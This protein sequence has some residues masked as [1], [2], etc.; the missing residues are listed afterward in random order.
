MGGVNSHMYGYFKMLMLKGFMA[1][2]KHMDKFIQIVE[3]MQTGTDLKCSVK[4][5]T[6]CLFLQL[7]L[8]LMYRKSSFISERNSQLFVSSRD[9][10]YFF[11][12]SLLYNDPYTR[13]IRQ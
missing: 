1:A 10:A 5:Y 11:F 2:R 8:K 13:D 9:T 3:I 7:F 6:T 4:G 12:I